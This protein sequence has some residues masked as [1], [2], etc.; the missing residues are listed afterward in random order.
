LWTFTSL[1]VV[2]VHRDISV[3]VSTCDRK[4]GFSG[5]MQAIKT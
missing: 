4:A 2:A 1:S 3:I 5:A